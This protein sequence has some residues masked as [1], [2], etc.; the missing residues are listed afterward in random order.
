MKT[1][2]F[3]LA[4]LFVL[5]SAAWPA[6][7]ATLDQQF[8]PDPG[9][10]LIIERAQSVAQT[11]TVGLSGLLDRIDVNVA[12]NAVAPPEGM[13]LEIRST[14][15]EGGLAPDVLASIFIP[16]ADV[17]A[18]FQY[19]EFDVTSFALTVTAGDVLALV[20]K[21]DAV[22]P[23]G[24]VDPFAWAADEAGG[25]GGGRVYADVGSGFNPITGWDVGFRTFVQA[26]T[27]PAPASLPLLV[28]GVMALA[29]RR[30]GRLSGRPAET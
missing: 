24:N 4:C 10:G 30:H 27:V 21:S 12:R 5:Y 25:Y 2:H 6:S 17:P 13:T 18:V 26:T 28:S 23:G 7:A 16:G 8:L 15:P 11:F 3:S 14:L 22:P 19:M 9:N 20:L 1:P 29:W